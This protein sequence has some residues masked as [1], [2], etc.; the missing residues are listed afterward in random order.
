MAEVPDRVSVGGKYASALAK[1]CSPAASLVQDDDEELCT[2]I[3]F[4]PRS[5]LMQAWC[6]RVPLSFN[7]WEVENMFREERRLKMQA[8]LRRISRLLWILAV[9]MGS[10]RGYRVARQ[11][12]APS[13]N[14]YFILA[15]ALTL[16]GMALALM[17]M[18]TCRLH[19]MLQ[20]ICLGSFQLLPL[21]LHGYRVRVIFGEDPDLV[22]SLNGKEYFSDT[23]LMLQLCA[24]M[25]FFGACRFPL[26]QH[27]L[28]S[29][30][31][32]CLYTAFTVPMPRSFEIGDRRALCMWLSVYCAA[33]LPGQINTDMVDRLNFLR[34]RLLNQDL[35]K[36]KVLRV[37]AE[38]EAEHGPL[39][40]HGQSAQSAIGSESSVGPSSIIFGALQYPDQQFEALTEL[41]QEEGWGIKPSFLHCDFQKELGSGG[42]GAVFKG[43]FLSSDVAV[44]VVS[45]HSLPARLQNLFVELRVL[46]H[47]RHPNVVQFLGACVWQQDHQILLVEELCSGQNLQVVVAGTELSEQDRYL[48]TLGICSALAYMHS[49]SPPIIHGD[50]KPSNVMLEPQTRKPKLVDFGMSR[51]LKSHAKPLGGTTRWMAPEVLSRKDTRPATQA[52]I[53]SFGRLV[54]FVATGILPLKY[55]MKEEVKELAC[56]CLSPELD[57]PKDASEWRSI[58]EPCLQAEPA[59][60][61]TAEAVLHELGVAAEAVRLKGETRSSTT[62]KS[63]QSLSDSS[64]DHE[65]KKVSL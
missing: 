16:S 63:L 38:H 49:R 34:R 45:D 31:V 28:L 26:A 2:E 52:D 11:Q 62:E 19:G 32:P 56:A 27:A 5:K 22:T 29:F 41:S 60:R 33:T 10:W 21:M 43:S 42:H 55:L 20:L 65:L 4:F 58:C 39:S 44:K 15:P 18:G 12:V 30:S 9:S 48:I 1:C 53:F 6:V 3:I 25:S 54:F 14:A 17:M 7:S 24:L 37:S 51:F 59:S 47:I 61:P 46:R 35:C 23:F 8:H 40:S 36:E 57:W 13:S 64:T 50:L